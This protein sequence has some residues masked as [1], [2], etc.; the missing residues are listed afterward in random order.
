MSAHNQ[1]ILE[2][3]FL[4]NLKIKVVALNAGDSTYIAIDTLTAPIEIT[5]SF[6]SSDID[7]LTIR[8]YE[9]ESFTGGTPLIPVAVNRDNNLSP[10]FTAS[11]NVITTPVTSPIEDVSYFSK[12]EGV[13]IPNTLT[14]FIFR[15]LTTY[16]LQIENTSNQSGGLGGNI[17]IG[18]RPNLG[19][20]MNPDIEVKGKFIR[21]KNEK[22]VFTLYFEARRVSSVKV[23]VGNRPN[24][25]GIDT[26]NSGTVVAKTYVNPLDL[27]TEVTRATQ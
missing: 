20:I 1:R 25:V 3:G 8:I 11:V 15:P 19:A 23:G 16:I 24:I 5:S 14:T 18:C 26:D 6:I 13:K 27:M 10:C 9:D 17:N 2:E 4:Y 22:D 21:F 7:D 12:V